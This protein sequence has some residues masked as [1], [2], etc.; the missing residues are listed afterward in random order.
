[1]RNPQ[2]YA[3]WTDPSGVAQ[4]RDTF[5]C[6]HCNS[7]VFVEPAKDPASLGGF[8]RLCMKNV[9]AKCADAGK[10]EPF[11]KKLEKMEARS[12]LLKSIGV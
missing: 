6:A 9:C 10:C 4:E 5:T 2:G 12:R 1:V 7:V 11:E 3:L 8:C